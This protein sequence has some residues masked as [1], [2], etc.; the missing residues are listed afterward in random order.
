MD[1]EFRKKMMS[2]KLIDFREI[3]EYNNIDFKFEDGNLLKVAALPCAIHSMLLKY[4]I[5][6]STRK[7]KTK[8]EKFTIELPFIERNTM[9]IIFKYMVS[10]IVQFSTKSI[11]KLIKAAFILQVNKII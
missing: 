7:V 6:S 5:F 2:E 3:K 11:Q 9:E 1:V 4:I 10:G 8:E